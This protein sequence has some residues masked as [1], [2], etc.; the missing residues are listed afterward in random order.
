[1]KWIE[2]N[3]SR[4]A[5]GVICFA[6]VVRLLFVAFYPYPSDPFSD[7]DA[8]EYHSIAKS[9][10]EGNG[11]AYAGSLTARRA[12]LYPLFLAG[13]HLLFGKSFMAVA[14]FQAIIDTISCYLIYLIAMKVFESGLVAIISALFYALYLPGIK[15]VGAI[16]TETL[17]VFL[18]LIF[19]LTL[20]RALDT[21]DWKIFLLS[22]IVLGVTS[23]CR[24]TTLLLPFFLILVLPLLLK[25]NVKIVALVKNLAILAI[26]T[27]I[28]ISPWLIRN[29]QVFSAVVPGSTGGGDAFYIGNHLLTYDLAEETI[30]TDNTWHRYHRTIAQAGHLPENEIEKNKVL[31][32][33]ALE[34]M[35]DYTPWQFAYI[36]TR[37][38]L[39]SFM[40]WD[41]ARIPLL[42]IGYL[43]VNGCLLL[44]GFAGF[45]TL[46]RDSRLRGMPLVVIIGYFIVIHTILVSGFRLN[47]PVIPYVIMFAA[48]GIVYFYTKKVTSKQSLPLRGSS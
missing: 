19:V 21:L 15:F 6:L 41:F 9:L 22:G 38:L 14:L 16:L 18:L 1:M 48:S 34:N 35:K 46:G 45:L 47:L 3:P 28:I 43:V 4:W 23:L 32:Q 44:F 30:P 29:Y 17:T 40:N 10:L 26:G 12:P 31:F 5:M 24:P 7:G 25:R 33:I 42:S 36:F 11:Y 2:D 13:M 37:K 20:L 8:I 39:N 27:A